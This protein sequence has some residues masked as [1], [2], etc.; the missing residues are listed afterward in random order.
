MFVSR[1]LAEATATVAVPSADRP[2]EGFVIFNVEIAPF[3]SSSADTSSLSN[4]TVSSSMT[5]FSS[6]SLLTATAMADIH[7]TASTAAISRILE[8]QIRDARAIDTEA[9]CIIPG[10]AVWVIQLDVRILNDNGNA[11]DVASIATMLSLLHL[12]RADVTVQG[13]KA[14]I[15]SYTE[16]VPIPLA[17]HHIPIC[18]SFALFSSKLTGK[19]K[20]IMSATMITNNEEEEN[21]TR[22]D[23]QVNSD[24]TY[25]LDPSNKESALADGNLT[26]VMNSHGELCGIQKLGGCPIHSA[27]MIQTT[28]I[29]SE[30]AVRL[31]EVMKKALTAADQMEVQKDRAK[32]AAIAGYSSPGTVDVH[33]SI[34]DGFLSSS[35]LPSTDGTVNKSI[36]NMVNTTVSEFQTDN[37]HKITN[38]NNGNKNIHRTM[39]NIETEDSVA[40]QTV[41]EMD[42]A[43]P[44]NE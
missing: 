34:F 16:R 40:T 26:Y 9:L 12:R 37:N 38:T 19:Q 10:Q 11:T 1:V 42:Y 7:G 32:H 6:T 18:I 2:L 20:F 5:S 31:V 27:T 30:Q 15:H 41:Q 21:Y 23:N 33:N 28:K 35:S 8:R 44:Q 14:I 17:I 36:A 24:D 29:A 4:S 13:G 43:V 22:T 25:I 3:A 39:L